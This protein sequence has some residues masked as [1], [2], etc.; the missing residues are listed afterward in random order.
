METK[1]GMYSSRLTKY[2]FT[3]RLFEGFQI[4]ILDNTVKLGYNDHG[5]NEFMFLT[6]KIFSHF[7]SQ[8]KLY[9]MYFHGYNESRLL[10]TYFAGPKEFVIT[11]F[12]RITFFICFCGSFWYSSVPWL[13]LFIIRYLCRN[14]YE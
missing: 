8:M 10:Q 5:Y 14:L 2:S 7:L 4:V 1:N 6:I 3:K 11:E 9:S 13:D 12:D